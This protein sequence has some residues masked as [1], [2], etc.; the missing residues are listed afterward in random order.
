MQQEWKEVGLFLRENM[1]QGTQFLTHA[2]SKQKVLEATVDERVDMLEM[3][4]AHL[5][6][7]K[8]EVEEKLQEV[9]ARIEANAEEEDSEG[10]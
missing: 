3:H 6:R 1:T 4:R 2:Q 7:Q 8:R 9:R 10:R 5:V